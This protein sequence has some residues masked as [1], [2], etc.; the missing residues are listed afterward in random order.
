MNTLD[1]KQF[2]RERKENLDFR[3][4]ITKKK[5]IHM[6]SESRPEIVAPSFLK[7]TRSF[8]QNLSQNMHQESSFC[9]RKD[10]FYE[11]S[12]C[13]S[14]TL[15]DRQSVDDFENNSINNSL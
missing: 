10:K 11:H 8:I 1:K 2:Q 15:S 9:E 7:N 12:D 4:I 14:I 6:A 13:H 3:S 5:E